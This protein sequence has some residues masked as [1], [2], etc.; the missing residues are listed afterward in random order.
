M[1]RVGSGSWLMV[2]F[3]IVVI[4]PAGSAVNAT[5]WLVTCLLGNYTWNNIFIVFKIL[6]KQM[7][8][9]S[10]VNCLTWV[11]IETHISTVEDLGLTHISTAV[12]YSSSLF[13][14][15]KFGYVSETQ[16]QSVYMNS[17]ACKKPSSTLSLEV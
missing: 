14:L 1:D 10:R 15:R 9:Y 7:L 12:P 8:K 2:S 16:K 6:N 17:E 3:D 13:F 4:G 11:K 5:V